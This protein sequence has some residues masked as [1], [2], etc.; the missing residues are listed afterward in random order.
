[1]G[2]ENTEISSEQIR[3]AFIEVLREFLTPIAGSSGNGT[4]V[5]NDLQIAL[6]QNGVAAKVLAHLSDPN[7]Y[8]QQFNLNDN[9]KQEVTRLIWNL[10]TR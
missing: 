2:N 1:M 6:I 3:V 10:I 5:R 9:G 7:H 8:G 4:T